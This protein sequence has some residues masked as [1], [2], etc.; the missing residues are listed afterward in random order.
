MSNAD[1]DSPRKFGDFETIKPETIFRFNDGETP[2]TFEYPVL[3]TIDGKGV[4]KKIMNNEMFDYLTS[5]G[6]IP[7][8]FNTQEV[9]KLSAEMQENAFLLLEK[10]GEHYVNIPKVDSGTPIIVERSDE[11]DKMQKINIIFAAVRAVKPRSDAGE[12]YFLAHPVNKDGL[13]QLSVVNQK[14]TDTSN[15]FT[16]PVWLVEPKNPFGKRYNR[17]DD[18]DTD[19]NTLTHII[20]YPFEPK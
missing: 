15:K 9:K 11:T 7:I 18:P 6:L 14:R 16:P 20:S 13:G 19:P 8:E 2:L 12:F 17:F 3:K 4:A 5:Q 10:T 1:E